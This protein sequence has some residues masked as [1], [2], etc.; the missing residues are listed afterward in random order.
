MNTPRWA[1]RPRGLVRSSFRR[2]RRWRRRAYAFAVTERGVRSL[3]SLVA[4]GLSAYVLTEGWESAAAVIGLLLFSISA[5]ICLL[6]IAPSQGVELW[7]AIDRRTSSVLNVVFRF[8]EARLRQL[9]VVVLA[10]VT[11]LSIVY[12]GWLIAGTEVRIE[13]QGNQQTT[14]R[15]DTTESGSTTFRN[16]GLV[17]AALLALPIAI[18]RTRV[19]QLQATT[20]QREHLDSLYRQGDQKLR[21]KDLSVRLDGVHIL[22]RLAKD[23]P[24]RY[25]IQIMERLCAFLRD[26][27]NV[28]QVDGSLQEDDRAVATAIRSRGESGRF[29]EAQSHFVL[30]L[31]G[32]NLKGVRFSRTVLAGADFSLTDLEDAKLDNADLSEAH[33]YRAN[34]S[35]ASIFDAE[36]SGARFSLNG[37]HPATGLTQEQIDQAWSDQDNLPTLDGVMDSVTGKQLTPPKYPKS[38]DMRMKE[39]RSKL[40]RI[41]G[42]S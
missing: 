37:K 19:A 3:I 13:T 1:K 34:L 6:A 21:D 10:V 35:G 33:F 25:H 5:G 28:Q 36:L 27:R 7:R 11:V 29:I 17:Y 38:L 32:T 2:I 20:A 42:E 24:D 16:L 15:I 23:E 14:I 41:R 40:D 18:W 9:T 4:A 31:Y 12:W 22:D 8:A 39:L 26:S 30:D